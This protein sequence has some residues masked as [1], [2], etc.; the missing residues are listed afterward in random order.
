[1]PQTGK[2]LAITLSSFVD[3]VER[4]LRAQVLEIGA[5]DHDGLRVLEATDVRGLRFRAVFI[6]GLF[7][8]GFVTGSIHMKS[9]ND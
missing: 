2:S 3:E 6:A 7:E 8:G 1:V 9:G 4:S 5:A